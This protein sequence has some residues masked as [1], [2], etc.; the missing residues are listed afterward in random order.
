[1]KTVR[2]LN[3]LNTKTNKWVV[4]WTPELVGL[5]MENQQ[6]PDLLDF[7]QTCRIARGVG[8]DMVTKRYQ[9]MVTPFVK[10]HL[11]EFNNLLARTGSMITGSCALNVLL[12]TPSHPIND[13]NIITNAKGWKAMDDFFVNTLGYIRTEQMAHPVLATRNHKWQMYSLNGREATLM[14]TKNPHDALQIIAKGPTT[15]EMTVMTARGVATLYPEWT[16]DYKGCTTNVGERMVT[17]W[18]AG[19]IGEPRF[20]ISKDTQ[21]LGKTCGRSC[22]ALWRSIQDHGEYIAR[23]WDAQF[24]VKRCLNSNDLE[25]RVS[26][27]CS[28]EHCPFRSEMV[29]RN[30]P[31]PPDKMP[32]MLGEI[33][34]QEEII[35]KHKPVSEITIDCGTQQLK[36]NKTYKGVYSGLLYA[37][38]DSELLERCIRD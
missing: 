33:R 27:Q 13:L 7:A 29:K 5:V 22:P 9:K 37:T 2:L 14:G 6:L 23:D 4:L 28:N 20:S 31:V 24:S 15:V 3:E 12:N 21:F 18:T 16:L 8:L 30:A 1:M 32:S 10:R 11:Q 17:A 34:E 19:S 26:K 36:E 35:C 25:W 38:N